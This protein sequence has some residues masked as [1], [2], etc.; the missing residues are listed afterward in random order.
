MATERT[1]KLCPA[2]KKIGAKRSKGA[3]LGGM[4][5]S[6]T[7]AGQAAIRR[8]VDSGVAEPQAVAIYQSVCDLVAD[9][10]TTSEAINTA[11]DKR[12]H[13][14]AGQLQATDDRL[15]QEIHAAIAEELDKRNYLTVEQ[16]LREL[17]KRN[18]LT[19]D[20]ARQ[21][22]REEI[23]AELDR[24]DY[25]TQDQLKAMESRLRLEMHQAIA[26]ELDKRKYVNEDKLEAVVSWQGLKTVGG[27][28][29]LLTLLQLLFDLWS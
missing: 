13:A 25:V 26:A 4:E 6:A 1:K 9:P 16:F 5:M 7:Y 18:Y 8:M 23:A 10:A 2:S 22:T 12:D 15:R 17:E 11:L 21:I 29:L 28:V 3:R 19:A 20:Q 24:R 14:T 27:T